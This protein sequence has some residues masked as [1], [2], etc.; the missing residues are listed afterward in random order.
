[1]L[2]KGFSFIVV[3]IASS[4]NRSKEVIDSEICYLAAQLLAYGQVR[5]EMHSGEDST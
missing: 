4:V 3:G 5:A 2:A 1:M